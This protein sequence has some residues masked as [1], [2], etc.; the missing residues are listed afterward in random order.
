MGGAVGQQRG[1]GV[2]AEDANAAIDLDP[3]LDDRLADLSHDQVGHV[4]RGVGERSGGSDERVRPLRWRA[5][6]PTPV[7]PPA[8][9]ARRPGPL[10]DRSPRPR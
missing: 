6:P 4:V 9:A 2:E 7:L 3:R 1:L 10:D 8:P 5:P